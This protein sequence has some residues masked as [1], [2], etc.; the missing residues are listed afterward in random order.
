MEWVKWLF[1]GILIAMLISIWI[2]FIKVKRWNE[3]KER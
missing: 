1:I 2:L 3:K